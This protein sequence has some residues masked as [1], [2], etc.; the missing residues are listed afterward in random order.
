MWLPV[1]E[2]EADDPDVVS[3]AERVVRAALS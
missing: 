2:R 1:G 3:Q